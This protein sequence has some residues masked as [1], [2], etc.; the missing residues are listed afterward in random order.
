MNKV[1]SPPFAVGRT[2]IVLYMC[3]RRRRV[4]RNCKSSSSSI[5]QEEEEQRDRIFEEFIAP[6]W[7]NT[8][9][10]CGIKKG[11]REREG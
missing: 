11:G 6:L 4:Y 1:E 5:M 7:R 8:V 10:G 3:R 9:R 2:V